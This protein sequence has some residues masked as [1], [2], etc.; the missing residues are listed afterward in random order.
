[1][2]TVTKNSIDKKR[3][4]STSNIARGSQTPEL[5]TLLWRIRAKMDEHATSGHTIGFTSCVSK[6]GVTT[7][8]A[9]LAIRASES[10]MGKVLLVDANLQSP[11][12]H[13]AFRV[14]PKS[15]LVDVLTGNSGPA[16]VIYET[17]RANLEFIPAGTAEAIASASVTTDNCLQFIQWAKQNYSLVILD[18]PV[19]AALRQSLMLARLADLNI[20]AVR[21]QSVRKS[22]LETLLQQAADDGLKVGGTVL[23][24]HRIYTPQ[25]LRKS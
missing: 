21:S 24:R 14:R 15:G 10:N 22:D 23:T 8:A 19:L 4:Q 25:F 18:L 9:N 17:T 16:E 11:K 20:V 3:N 2:S 7:L 13:R 1:M 5:D 12:L 6:S